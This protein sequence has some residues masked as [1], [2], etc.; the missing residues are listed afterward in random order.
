MN[1]K[2]SCVIATKNRGHLIKGM[3]MSLKHQ[4]MQD[5]E[6]I[7]VEDMCEDWTT[8]VIGTIADKRIKNFSNPGVGKS[9][10]LNAA[11][12]HI[13]GKYVCLFD[14][15]DVMMPCKLDYSYRMMEE[16][17]A[18]FGYSA[19][20]THLLNNQITYTPTRAFDMAYFL[21]KPF[22]G[23]GG[24]IMKK[25]LFMKIDFDEELQASM[26]FDFIGKCALEDPKMV[27]TQ[28]PLYL[29]RNHQ[30]SITFNSNILQRICYDKSKAKLEKKW[31][32]SKVK[33]EVIEW[34]GRQKDTKDK[35]D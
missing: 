1:P 7:I 30:D 23:F 25:D 34:D 24:I 6:C 16:T 10:A 9:A 29:W 26:D 8:F 32:R 21:E 19:R 15:D 14:D 11:K 27:Y 28:I 33:T 5:W 13:K 35:A 20:F 12:E 18:D 2:I 22:I 31:K 4:V 3:L 17:N